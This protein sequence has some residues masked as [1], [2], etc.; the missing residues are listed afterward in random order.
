MTVIECPR[1]TEVLEC[2]T[3]GR[4]PDGCDDELR[5][6]ASSCALCAD[7][8]TVATAIA[9]DMHAAMRAA[10]VPSSGT[11][12][13]RMQRRQR[14]D[15][16]RMAS[17]AITLVQATSV[18]AALAFAMTLLGGAAA[19][20]DTWRTWLS[21][22]SD[23]IHFGSGLPVVTLNAPLLFALAASLLLAPVAVYLAVAKD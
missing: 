8:V 12:W 15:I 13:W 22:M 16:A 2:V 20:S 14:A 9:E 4:W 21:R 17:R 6:H 7:L 23:A 11:V 1:E 18:V 10:D 3:A 19:L 5:A